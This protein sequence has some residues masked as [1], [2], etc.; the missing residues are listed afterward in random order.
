MRKVASLATALALGIAG[1]AMAQQT[2]TEPQV[3]S[4]LA[5]QGYTRIHDLKF[6]DGMWQADARSADGNRLEVRVDPASGKVFPD[7]SASRLSEDDIRASLANSGYTHVHDV[8]FEDGLWTAKAHD[9]S[10]ERVELRLDPA[11][12]RVIAK[13]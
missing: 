8:E 1:A 3:R 11:T 6:H 13:E 12:G 2:M 7:E 9:A 10:G 5:E 4:T